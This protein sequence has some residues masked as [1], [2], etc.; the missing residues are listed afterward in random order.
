MLLYYVHGAIYQERGLLTSA[1]KTI[2]NKGEI[3]ALLE[4]LW[5]PQQVAVIHCKGHQRENMAVARGNQKAD[6]EAWDSA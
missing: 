4:A 2:K 3:L 6:S 5:L 1:G